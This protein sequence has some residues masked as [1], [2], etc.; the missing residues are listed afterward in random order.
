M[1]PQT[2]RQQQEL[3]IH[4]V[5]QSKIAVVCGDADRTQSVLYVR[6]LLTFLYHPSHKPRRLFLALVRTRIVRLFRAHTL[7][8]GGTRS[9]AGAGPARVP[10]S[11]ADSKRR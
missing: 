10:R 2:I 8:T 6:A 4:S 1:P 9:V 7:L 5:D 3:S 11:S